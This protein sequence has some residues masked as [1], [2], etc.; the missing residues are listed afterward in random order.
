MPFP[1]ALVDTRFSGKPAATLKKIGFSDCNDPEL[2]EDAR[3]A[4]GLNEVI[5]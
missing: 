2:H 1:S 4:A 5:V 3:N